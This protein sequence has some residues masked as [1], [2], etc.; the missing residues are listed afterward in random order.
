ML[1]VKTAHHRRGRKRPG[2]TPSYACDDR[3]PS[4]ADC[5]RAAV[6]E[7][8]LTLSDNQLSC[9]DAGPDLTALGVLP[10]ERYGPLPS[11]CHRRD[12]HRRATA[13][14]DHGNGGHKRHV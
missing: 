4:L 14:F 9:L 8:G 12:E 5:N 11:L 10:A 13:I 6:P 7:V 2:F 1:M 3:R